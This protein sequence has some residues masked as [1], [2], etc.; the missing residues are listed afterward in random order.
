MELR[1][2]LQQLK[3]VQD[4]L[5]KRIA[6]LETERKAEKPKRK[7]KSTYVPKLKWT[8]MPTKQEI[9]ERIDRK[10]AKKKAA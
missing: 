7:R 10:F 8:K 5:I 3:D 6:R 2:E 1:E 9:H 4:I